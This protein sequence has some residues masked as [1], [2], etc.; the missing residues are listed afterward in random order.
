MNG[1]NREQKVRDVG[2]SRFDAR[3]DV[4]RRE[5]RRCAGLRRWEC[6]KVMELDCSFLVTFTPARFL[7]I[8]KSAQGSL[9]H[10]NASKG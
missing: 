3:G 2:D 4:L 1:R 6:F 10:S 8:A 7:I 5:V 9:V